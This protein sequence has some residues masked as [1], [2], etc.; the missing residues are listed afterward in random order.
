MDPTAEAKTRTAHTKRESTDAVSPFS[1][2]IRC[3]GLTSGMAEIDRLAKELPK[4]LAVYTYKLSM[5][6]S[7]VVFLGGTG[8][9]KS[10]LFNAF[11]GMPLSETG[12]ERP[13]TCGPILFAHKNCPL[14]NGFPFGPVEIEYLSS[15][16][17]GA[18]GVNGQPGHLLVL[19]H[20]RQEWEHLIVVDTPDLD[21]VETAN[22]RMALD[23]YLLSDASI[24]VTSQ[25]KYADEIPYQLLQR[26]SHEKTPC[27]FILNKAQDRSSIEEVAVTLKTHGV[28][29]GKEHVWSI[30]FAPLC[31]WEWI[32]E[33][34]VFHDFID[35]FSAEFSAE[36]AEGF[37]E[38]HHRIRRADLGSG[39]GRL[40]ELIQREE[41]AAGQWLDRLDALHQE[42]SQELIREQKDRFTTESRGYLQNEIRR[43]FTKYDVLAKP[44]RLA[45]ALLLTPF[46]LLGFRSKGDRKE[47]EQ[48]LLKVRKKIDLTPVQMSI[49]KFNRLVLEN[50]SPSDENA[51]LFLRLRDPD[52]SM[53]D[54]EIKQVVWAEQDHMAAWLEETFN[55][56]SEGIPKTKEWGIYST[57]LLWGILILS[58][59]TV[60]GGGFTVIDAVLDAALAPFITKGAMELFAYHEIQKVAKELAKRYQEGLVSVLRRQRD[61]YEECLEALITPVA[62]LEALRRS[63]DKRGQRL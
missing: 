2:G 30:P 28:S 12:V 45:K 48:G 17:F 51:P 31:S 46:R 13:K 18:K 60:V 50:L 6:Y 21:S 10:T 19:Q 41:L 63:L 35:R 1:G 52:V 4:K 42:M 9:G 3:P 55:R 43:L 20:D 22:R 44:R 49:L 39:L 47:H 36:K 32:A 24:F 40:I 58:F 26:I 7:W 59:E 8:T 14:E 27:F 61:R 54:Q 5:P 57:S 34:R 11:C 56:L 29:F 23:L 37:R 62:D 53:S 33:Q 38:E 16:D 25:E 15:R